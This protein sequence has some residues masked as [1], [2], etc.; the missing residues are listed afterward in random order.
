MNKVKYSHQKLFQT[1]FIV[2]ILSL[3][4]ISILFN[5]GEN[6][7]ETAYEF[8]NSIIKGNSRFA[9]QLLTPKAK[10]AIDR[11]S[12]TSIESAIE[13]FEKS[14]LKKLDID[15]IGIFDAKLTNSDG[16]IY[17]HRG[18]GGWRVE[19]IGPAVPK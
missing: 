9:W 5:A 1:I 11:N 4:I 13:A 7:I 12:V 19:Y 6:L 8:Q 17:F 3:Y 18:I 10:K 16:V 2:F 14:K 15:G